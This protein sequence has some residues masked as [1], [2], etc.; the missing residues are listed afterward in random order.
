MI[1][2][3]RYFDNIKKKQK[4]KNEFFSIFN[5]RSGWILALVLNII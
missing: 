1:F 5:K 3:I 2:Y 4:K